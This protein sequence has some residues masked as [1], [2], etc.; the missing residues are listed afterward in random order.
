MTLRIFGLGDALA[1]IDEWKSP[2]FQTQP[3]QELIL[4]VAL[5]LVLA[6]GVKLPLDA[7]C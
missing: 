6:R 4:L 2:D 3:L 5:Y 1:L 7:R